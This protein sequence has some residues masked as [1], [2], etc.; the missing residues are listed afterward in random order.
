MHRKDSL[1]ISVQP[2]E[3]KALEK[4]IKK[5][6]TNRSSKDRDGQQGTRQYRE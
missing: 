1:V 6:I 3:I 4:G 5:C 2:E